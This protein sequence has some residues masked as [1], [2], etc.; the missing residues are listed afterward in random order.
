MVQI[1]VMRG[2]KSQEIEKPPSSD[3]ESLT[4]AQRT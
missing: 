4:D 3:E 1:L 2:I